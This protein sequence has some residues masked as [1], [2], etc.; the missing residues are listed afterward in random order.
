MP[1][2]EYPPNNSPLHLPPHES[3]YPPDW[4]LSYHSENCEDPSKSKVAI[5]S[6]YFHAPTHDRNTR[7]GRT[8]LNNLAETGSD[9][10]KWHAV[11]V[12]C[13]ASIVFLCGTQHSAC[14][15][16]ANPRKKTTGRSVPSEKTSPVASSI[17]SS[18]QS[19]AP[20][21]PARIVLKSGTLSIEAN[22]SDLDQIL[23]EIARTSGMRISGSAGRTRVYGV[24]GPQDP[25]D[26][27]TDLLAGT[28]NNIMMV[29]RTPTGTP[30]ELLL[31]PKGGAPSPPAVPQAP[32]T[33]VQ[34]DRST[35][36][37]PNSRVPGQLGPGAIPAGPPPPSENPEERIQ[38]NLHRLQQMQDRQNAKP[39]QQ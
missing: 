6:E 19:V 30:R 14:Q 23:T 24:Y 4:S 10:G 21:S 1:E 37:N 11:Y 7:Y 17:S 9:P 31:T 22:N 18:T 33:P 5:H 38:Q 15:A 2:G 29:G 36:D 26:V 16:Q 39:P 20:P 25:A 8:N 28:G 12:M 3:P 13:V 27:L 34:S 32:V 35:I